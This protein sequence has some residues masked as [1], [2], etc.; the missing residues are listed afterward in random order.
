MVPL[1]LKKKQVCHNFLLHNAG[2]NLK[3]TAAHLSESWLSFQQGNLV[4]KRADV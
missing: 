3:E 2:T 4:V 1:T